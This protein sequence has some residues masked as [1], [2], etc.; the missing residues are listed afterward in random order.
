MSVLLVDGDNLLTIGFFGVKNY[1][2]KGKHIGGIY[3]F[4]NTL[5][6]S[7]ETYHLD[8]I[9][10]FWDGADS[11]ATRKKIYHLYKDTRRSNRWTDEAQSSYDYQ[12]IRIKQYLE[13]LYV[14][15]GEYENCESDDCIAYYSQNS[16]KEKKIIYSSDRDLAQL[17]SQDT[18][19][20]NPA[21]GKIYKPGDNIEYDH[22]TILIENVKIVK[23]LCGDPSD[24]IF[25]IRNLG[26]KRMI[27][28]FPEMQTKI[29]TLN[30]VRVKAEEIWQG[31]KHNKTLQNLL[32]GV[33][34][35]GVLGEEFFETNEKI[36]DLTEP[37][38]TDIAKT[39]IHDLI[40]E[41]LD[42]EGRSYKNTMKMMMD[43]GM[44]TV[45]P[46]QEDAWI[47]FLNPFLRL[48]RKEKNK[49]IIKFK[50]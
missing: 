4:L 8:K 5:R 50:I 48:T 46:K 3:H 25:G 40:N 47:K 2:Y 16:P 12:R 36:V 27:A 31:D 29:L 43:D 44:F 38:L 30:E 19:L 34:K 22:E 28:L 18:E 24:N 41:T 45:L 37:I 17:V 7:F 9:C 1:F 15:Q 21:H 11:A 33:S 42:S 26:L 10:V 39:Q 6:K 20:Y 13:E 23:M 32:T 14:R 35:L 49:K